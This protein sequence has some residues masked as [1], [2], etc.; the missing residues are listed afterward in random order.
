MMEDEAGMWA[1]VEGTPRGEVPS[2]D[3]IDTPSQRD[4]LLGNVG[5]GKEGGRRGVVDADKLVSTEFLDGHAQG[6]AVGIEEGDIW[7]AVED[8]RFRGHGMEGG[9]ALG[10]GGDFLSGG[11]TGAGPLG[12]AGHGN[13]VNEMDQV[14]SGLPSHPNPSQV[15]QGRDSRA[16]GVTSRFSWAVNNE[17]EVARDPRLLEEMSRCD[18]TSCTPR[19]VWV[20]LRRRSR[21]ADAVLNSLAAETLSTRCFAGCDL[22][23][24]TATLSSSRL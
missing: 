24:R 6:G 21:P 23:R 15:D 1:M 16:S 4:A 9:L 13:Y 8:E 5:R 17:E 10:G 19:S 20:V 18:P 22:L 14:G 12:E 3:V 7:D 11:K 2:W